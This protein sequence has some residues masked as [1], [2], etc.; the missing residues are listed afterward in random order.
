MEVISKIFNKWLI[1]IHKIL[2]YP[3]YKTKVKLFGVPTL[4]HRSNIYLGKGTRIN[5]NVVLQADGGITIG[6][7]VTLSR[8]VSVISTGYDASNWTENKKLKKHVNAPIKIGE[9]TWI[10]ANTVI[11]KGVTIGNGCIIGA[12]SVVTKDLKENNAL[13]AG[14]PAR[15]IKY[16]Y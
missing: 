5:Q 1:I 13:Y 16:L 7:G 10:G 12:G 2:N 14:N 11:L 3:L 6:D 9:Y 4:I 15:F 8:N